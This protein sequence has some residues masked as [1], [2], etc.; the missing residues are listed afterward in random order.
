MIVNCTL[1]MTGEYKV[2]KLRGS[3]VTF[4][5]D[6]FPNIITDNGLDLWA[7]SSAK[8]AEGFV[9]TGNATPQKSDISLANY[10]AAD[11]SNYGATK[12]IDTNEYCMYLQKA[13]EF[14]EGVATGN[15]SEL[16]VGPA[17]NNFFSRALVRDADGSPT[18]I[19]VLADEKLRFYYRL[20]IN[21]P[22]N[23]FVAQVDGY[24]TTLRAANADVAASWS[25]GM[26]GQPLFGSQ[27]SPL[28]SATMATD[29]V[30]ADVNNPPTG[31]R[32]YV[33]SATTD[34][35]V[36]GSHVLSGTLLWDTS[37]G[38]GTLSAFQFV[39]YGMGTWQFSISPAITKGFTQR[40]SIGVRIRWAREGEL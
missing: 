19:S 34:S 6:W 29:G 21:Q 14:N 40:L 23:D 32:F 15:I 24:S 7:T 27:Q 18:T 39:I 16:G 38:N 31:N 8:F 5:S 22:L 36:P 4:E 20:R 30:I 33:T 25:D 1:G 28:S 10:L 35:Y 12:S 26:D 13:F 11:T 3:T 2:E 9:G 37:E 17:N